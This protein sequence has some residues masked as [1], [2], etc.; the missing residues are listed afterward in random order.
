[1]VEVKDDDD[2]IDTATITINVNDVNEA[3]IANPDNYETD[4]DTT[5]TILPIDALS[6]G[7]LAN[8]EDIDDAIANLLIDSNTAPSN[9]ILSLAVDGSFIYTPTADFFGVATFTYIAKDDDNLTSNSA[10][11]TIMVNAVNDLPVAN[12]DGPLPQLTTDEDTPFDIPF[13]LLTANDSPGPANESGQDLTAVNP[14]QPANGSITISGSN[15][16]YTPN[17][18]FNGTDTFEYYVQDSGVEPNTSLLP[19]TVIV[20][21]DSVND[22]PILNVATLSVKEV[23]TDISDGDDGSGIG[24]SVGTVTAEDTND[25]PEDTPF[26]FGTMPGGDGYTRFGINAASGEI[27]VI[28]TTGLDMEGSTQSFTLTVVVTDSAN[29]TATA[30]FPIDLIDVNEFDPVIAPNQ[31]FTITETAQPNDLVNAAP[32]TA[33]DEDHQDVSSA[34]AI[35]G[36]TG[37]SLFTI[38]NSGNIRVAA[39][40]SFDYEGGTNSYTLDI[41]VTDNGDTPGTR[42]GSQTVQIDIADANEPPVLGSLAVDPTAVVEGGDLVNL[43]GT[44]TDQ[45][46]G[47]TTH[48][49]T[50]DWGDGSTTMWNNATDIDGS[51]QYKDDPSGSPDTYTIRVT[52]ADR[53]D[54]TALTDTDTIEVTVTNVDP[55]LSGVSITPSPINEGESATLSG[56]ISDAGVEDTFS[57]QVTWGDGQVITYPYP[58]QPSGLPFTFD[59]N[60]IFED[61][62]Q[63]LTVDLLLIDDDGGQHQY[64]GGVDI[65]VNNVAPEVD[66]GKNQIVNVGETVSFTGVIT[67]PGTADTHTKLWDFGDSATDNTNIL[68][69]EHTY[70]A[71]GVYTVNLTVTDD[72]GGVGS[73]TMTVTVV[74][75]S[76]MKATKAVRGSF[77]EEGTVF[78]T[79]TLINN[80]DSDQLDNAGD[81]LT[82]ML[83][84]QLALV[85]AQ[86]ISGGGTVTKVV[87]TN[88]VTWNGA[89]ASGSS[90]EIEIEAMILPDTK[91]AAVSNQAT[92]AYDE[93]G[94]GSN[95]ATTYSDDPAVAGSYDPTVFNVADE[96]LVF[97]PIVVKNYTSAP[98]LVVTNINASSDLIEVVIENQGNAPVTNSFWVDFYINPNPVPTAANDLWPESGP[99]PQGLAWGVTERL[100]VGASLT[101]SYSTASGAPNL[102]F[103]ADESLY[104]GS[105][106]AGTPVYAQADSARAGVGLGAVAE[107]DELTGKPYNNILG[108]TAVPVSSTTP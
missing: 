92:I 41:S 94:N 56:T 32:I 1:M 67:D 36:G 72:D 22:A 35:T 43:T 20:T 87:A 73:D 47:D 97:I 15:F 12:D 108:G 5:L 7:V 66:A 89:V 33:T 19:A 101:L 68:T 10:T 80:G 25:T 2:E 99:N 54:E 17:A 70:T 90:V 21:V 51:H 40:A 96:Y 77:T 6:K 50:V 13:S 39:G 61:D 91:G 44:I 88:T 86:V 37:Q 38:D 53:D 83:P 71:I 84:P 49:V 31:V 93:D 100:A 69:P 11:V 48:H 59:V 34:F 78:Y 105:M 58:V 4:E 8:D 104:D 107:L 3:P 102:Y 26:E 52:V 74:S 29:L 27:T 103:V 85:D 76:D 98:D 23:D 65:T 24:K 18:N 75:P 42:T 14:S 95:E 82:D 79:I 30:V 63:P 45:D 62:G 60:H 55:V 16:R 46:T 64:P 28:D 57:L 106:P 9:G 81:E